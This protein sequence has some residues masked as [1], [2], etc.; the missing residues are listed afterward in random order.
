MKAAFIITGSEIITG[1][2]QDAL[3]QP[4]AVKLTAKGIPVSEVRMLGD[5]PADLSETVAS[6]KADLVIV[7]GG[8]GE[9]PDDTT[10]KAVTT[11]P[12]IE[13]INQIEN[14]VGSAKGI[15]LKFPGKRV[16]FFPGV[17]REAYAMLDIILAEMPDVSLP[18][19]NIPVFGM[20][21]QEI[22]RMIGLSAERCGFL[23]KDMEITV[24][25]PV[26]LEG[27]I[28]NILGRH[29]LEYGDLTTTIGRLL[30]VKGLRCAAA[31]SCTGGAIGHLLTA[32]PGSSKYFLGS[33]VA[34]NNSVKA[35]LLGVPADMIT[36]YG[37]V[38]EQVAS[39]MLSGV[40]KVT[41]ADIGMAVTGI[42]GPDGGT[43]EKPVGT[44]WIA[45]GTPKDQ[46]IR[47]FNFGFDRLGNK[48]ISAK[49]ALYMMRSF[50]HDKGVH[51]FTL[52]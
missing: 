10:R 31:E 52:A 4:F 46:L 35:G 40:L 11:I 14:P 34:Y 37:A 48:L 8:L 20:R 12:G 47:K 2:R 22:A 30:A 50:I 9:T 19:V 17:P 42:A 1:K 43:P 49:V 51:G 33:V 5:N 21:E 7:T 39:R 45:V 16:V 25:A 29:A 32:V 28:R 3:V 41:G 13:D 6:V 26:E 24:V 36:E 44:V 23:P 15:D 27:Q 38:S 18:T